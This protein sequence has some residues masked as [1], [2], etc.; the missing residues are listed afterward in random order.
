MG[1]VVLTIRKSWED[2]NG[3]ATWPCWEV[4]GS[5]ML[6]WGIQTWWVCE[7]MHACNW[8]LKEDSAEQSR[9]TWSLRHTLSFCLSSIE[10]ACT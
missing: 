5:H 3:C 2:T 10:I 9:G 6:A 7:E 1:N 8:A 4:I